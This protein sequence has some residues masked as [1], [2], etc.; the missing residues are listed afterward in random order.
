MQ[1]TAATAKPTPPASAAGPTP[2]AA[3]STAAPYRP[4]TAAPQAVPVDSPDK[5]TAGIFVLVWFE[6]LNYGYATGDA[7]PLR[8]SV[9]LGC[10]TCVNWIKEVQTQADKRMRRTGGFVHVRNL[11]F[12]GTSGKD[13][14]FRAAL[15]RDPGALTTPDGA[16]EPVVPGAGEVVDLLVGIATSTLTKSKMW[17]MQSVAAPTG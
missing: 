9:A 15:D 4:L 17:V 3:S 16:T 7:D 14:R 8:K 2:A 5:T 6:T 11:A 13:F 10:F 1:A 12:T